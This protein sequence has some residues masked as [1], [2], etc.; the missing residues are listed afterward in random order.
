MKRFLRRF[1]REERGVSAIEYV[2]LLALV[3]AGIASA[4]LALGQA[5]S[6]PPKPVKIIHV[7]GPQANVY[8]NQRTITV[9]INRAVTEADMRMV[10][11]MEGVS[12]VRPISRHEGII[13]INFRKDYILAENYG[14]FLKRLEKVLSISFGRGLDRSPGGG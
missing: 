11:A 9:I 2:L 13:N 5:I 6:R 14:K 12:C 3:G 7:G 4:I 1:A 8:P 10:R